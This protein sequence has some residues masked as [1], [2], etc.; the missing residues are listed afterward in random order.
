MN[1]MSSQKE[2]RDFRLSLLACDYGGEAAFAKTVHWVGDQKYLIALYLPSKGYDYDDG[3]D[4][5]FIGYA[6]NFPLRTHFGLC[7]DDLM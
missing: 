3:N 6:H 2:L 5:I 4:L 7:H 1:A